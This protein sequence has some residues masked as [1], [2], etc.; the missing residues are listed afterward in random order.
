MAWMEHRNIKFSVNSTE[1]IREVRRP[2][3]KKKKK[4]M[5]LKRIG[6]ISP[7][8]NS[9]DIFSLAKSLGWSTD[10]DEASVKNVNTFE[11]EVVATVSPPKLQTSSH[12]EDRVEEKETGAKLGATIGDDVI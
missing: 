7:I 8:T 10:E 3:V 12:Q 2:N 1:T 5:P 11:N 9:K 6:I 4:P